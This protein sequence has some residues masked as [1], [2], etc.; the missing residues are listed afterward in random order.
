MFCDDDVVVRRSKIHRVGLFAARDFK[1]GEVV[2][3]WRGL[4]YTAEQFRHCDT[5][6]KPYIA[7][8]KGR[9]YLMPKPARFMNHSCDPNTRTRRLGVDVAS[10]NIAKGEEITSDYLLE[11]LLRGEFVCK[12]GSKLCASWTGV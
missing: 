9:Y 7:H 8:I 10:R 3:R 2:V 12:C 6:I 11:A 4:R 5:R 1:Y